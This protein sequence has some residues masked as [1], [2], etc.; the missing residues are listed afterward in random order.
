MG[1][2]ADFFL[3]A[4]KNDSNMGVFI[5][6][7]D[8]P[9]VEVIEIKGLLGNRGSHISE[10]VFTNVSVS[11]E[12]LLGEIDPGLNKVVAYAL[13]LGRY[14]AAWSAIALANACLDEM[15]AYSRNRLQFGQKIRTYESIQ[16]IIG[17]A[18]ANIH[19]A[20]ALALNAGELRKTHSPHAAYETNI[21]KFFCSKVV[22]QIASDTIQIHGANGYYDEYNAERYFREA[23]A[24]EIIEGTSQIMLQLIS[25]SALINGF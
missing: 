8:R 5:V 4:A 18:A 24:F 20:K 22:N 6:K 1:G 7:K 21:A 12:N 11:R 16:Q 15:I 14:S 17:N 10:I 19:A 2:L 13:D 25:R 3:V 23:K 9:G